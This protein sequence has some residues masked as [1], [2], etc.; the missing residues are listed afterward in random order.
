MWRIASFWLV[1]TACGFSGRGTPLVDPSTV[2]FEFPTTN[3]D[4]QSSDLMVSVKLDKPYDLRLTVTAKVIGGSAMRGKDYLMDDTI[5]VFAPGDVVATFPVAI[6]ADDLEEQEETIDLELVNVDGALLGASRHT[7]RI[8]NDILPRVQFSTAVSDLAENL[9]ATLDVSLDKASS[10]PLT[11]E[12]LVDDL[13]TTATNN[14]TDFQLPPTTTITFAPGELTKSMALPIT[15]DLLDEDAETIG[16]QL[17]NP[18]AGLILTTD[19]TVKQVHTID[20][21]DAEPVLGFDTA[22][23]TGAEGTDFKLAVKLTPASGRVVTVSFARAGSATDAEATLQTPTT[24]TFQPGTTS[25]DV[26]FT[27]TDDTVDEPAQAITIP[28]TVVAGTATQGNSGSGDFYVSTASPL[29]IAAGANTATIVVVL[30][31]DKTKEANETFSLVLGTPTNA[32]LGTFPTRVITII[33]N[34]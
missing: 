5:L 31:G 6:L 32:T 29:T 22:T 3:A 27:A 33:D 8:S 7:I 18:S 19:P 13:A 17:A 21:D 11:V 4:E 12:V 10:V 23:S 24:L 28:F 34:D 25:L 2:G 26:S 15:D 30:R 16:V 20:D 1:V 9:A 14:G